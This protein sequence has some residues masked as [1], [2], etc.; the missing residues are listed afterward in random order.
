MD[1]SWRVFH[2][3]MEP[4]PYT[5]VSVNRRNNEVRVS[6]DTNAGLHGTGS[7]KIWKTRHEISVDIRI[8]FTVSM[9]TATAWQMPAA[10]AAAAAAA[11][12]ALQ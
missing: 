2:I 5:F 1:I 8:F 11:G 4:V 10:A 3:L 12:V 9:L 6:P 7:V